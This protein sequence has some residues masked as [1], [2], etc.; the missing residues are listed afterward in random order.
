MF[1]RGTPPAMHHLGYDL[2]ERTGFDGLW[3]AMDEPTSAPLASAAVERHV[4]A[5]SDGAS[6]PVVRTRLVAFRAA[7]A[8]LDA[9]DEDVAA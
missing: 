2:P 5:R 7:L 9:A 8:A 6:S 3:S 1:G 4:I